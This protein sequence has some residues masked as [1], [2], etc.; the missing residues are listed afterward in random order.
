LLLLTLSA[1]TTTL[2]LSRFLHLLYKIKAPSEN[3]APDYLFSW[4]LLLLAGGWWTMSAALLPTELMNYVTKEKG[5]MSFFWNL[6]KNWD[7][8]WPIA[9]GLLLMAL[10]VRF[11]IFNWWPTKKPLLPAGDFLHI[12][13]LAGDL[14]AKVLRKRIS[15]LQSFMQ[16]LHGPEKIFY[17][18]SDDKRTS[19]IS[20]FG[21]SLLRRWEFV[22]IGFFIF[23]LT[24]FFLLR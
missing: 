2:L 1:V 4:L 21:E 5:I 10:S 3:V 15:F 8:L 18:I 19:Q 14:V 9:I 6:L 20:A 12:I 23:F 13:I 16:S 7:A 24:L 22:G 11:A 17:R